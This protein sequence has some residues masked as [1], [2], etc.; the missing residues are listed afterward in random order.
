V[1]EPSGHYREADVLSHGTIEQLFVLLRLALARHLGSAEETA[2]LILDEITVQS[3]TE[4]TRAMLD[5]LLELSLER[6]IVL[7]SQEDDVVSWA[8][9]SMAG[10]HSA[11]I[12]LS[13]P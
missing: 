1:L 13:Q 11:V 7:F 8:R 4:R 10:Q 12:E 6:Q 5:L 3:D 9:R 2:P